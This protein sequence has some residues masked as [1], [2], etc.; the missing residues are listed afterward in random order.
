MANFLFL[1]IFEGSYVFLRLSSF[2]ILFIL[3]F[4]F[5]LL[6]S[7]EIFSYVRYTPEEKTSKKVVSTTKKV[8]NATN[9]TDGRTRYSKEKI[10]QA[11]TISTSFT[12]RNNFN[13]SSFSD[14]DFSDRELFIELFVEMQRKNIGMRNTQ[15]LKIGDRMY[16]G[17]GKNDGFLI[18]LVPLPSKLASIE[19]DGKTYIF[20]ILKPS[21]FPYEKE[22]E[23]KSFI[24]RVFII[25]SEKGYH[26]YITFLPH[27]M[28]CKSRDFHIKYG[29]C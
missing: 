2:F 29:I 22:R 17:G 3:V 20:K 6:I 16:V 1:N 21:F 18:F 28:L 10:T 25:V 15:R 4:V 5:V 13:D 7:K 27:E 23:V 14:I 26:I 19:Y 24:G 11:N 8:V 12:H 9:K